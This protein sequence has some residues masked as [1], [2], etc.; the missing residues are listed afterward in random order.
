[1]D[2]I[3]IATYN[4]RQGGSLQNWLKI[5]EVADPDLLLVQESKD[6]STFSRDLIEPLDVEGVLWR[7]VAENKWG[8][9]IWA[10]SSSLEEIPVPGFEGWVIGGRTDLRGISTMIFSVHLPPRGGSYV[11]SG[12]ELMD[13][14]GPLIGDSTC[15]LGGDWNFTVAM[16]DPGD[17]RGHR[18]GEVEFLLRMVDEFAL[19]PAWRVV[20]PEGKLPQT[21]RWMRDPRTP[22]HCD[23]VFMTEALASQVTS[24]EVLSGPPWLTLSDHN[25]VVFELGPTAA[26]EAF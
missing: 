16:R 4:M 10:R 7:P 8:S 19:V 2:L 23:G 9:A 18:R 24:A 6:P 22:Y 13:V 21:L 26:A 25:P 17:P 1:M 5:R 3:R 15:I 20:H 14:L 11:Q 12:N